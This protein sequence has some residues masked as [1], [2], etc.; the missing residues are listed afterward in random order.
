M[1][2][3]VRELT[4]SGD[5]WH[6]WNFN[7]R[8]YGPDVPPGTYPVKRVQMPGINRPCI[9]LEHPEVI[10]APKSALIGEDEEFLRKNDKRDLCVL[11]LI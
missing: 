6:P 1:K 8:Q 11:Q 10:G 7:A 2:Q 5:R 4:V 9:V 3:S